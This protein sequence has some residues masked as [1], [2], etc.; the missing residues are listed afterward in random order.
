MSEIIGSDT[1]RLPC[2]SPHE[3]IRGAMQIDFLRPHEGARIIAWLFSVSSALSL[4]GSLSPPCVPWYLSFLHNIC[5]LLETPP[6]THAKNRP[7]NMLRLAPSCPP[8][9]T[10]D[11]ISA[12][13]RLRM[14]CFCVVPLRPSCE[15]A[16]G[17]HTQELP[18]T[19][20]DYPIAN[21]SNYQ[22][23][24]EQLAGEKK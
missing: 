4:S 5:Y 8:L 13:S 2:F 19:S 1:L 17:S 15:L 7:K 23:P 22:S 24:P 3:I 16:N 18:I 12:R 14:K 20:N 11:L 9:Y 10:Q 6:H 21:D